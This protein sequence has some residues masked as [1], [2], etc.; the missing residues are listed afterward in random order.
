[1]VG[2]HFSFFLGRVPLSGLN[3]SFVFFRPQN[4]E[5]VVTS[6]AQKFQVTLLSVTLHDKEN[7]MTEVISSFVSTR[8]FFF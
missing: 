2:D 6:S 1:M 5:A 4:P 7:C 3:D 8:F